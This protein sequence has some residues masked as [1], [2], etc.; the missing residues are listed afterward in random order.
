MAHIERNILQEKLNQAK[1]QI[2]IGDKYRHTKTGGEYL[3]KDLGIREDTE[4][5]DVIYEE[6]SHPEHI[7]WIRSLEG[8]DGWL[9]PTEINGELV[10][11]FTKIK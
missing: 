1:K 9:T 10:P 6:L 5:I 2:T 7:I 8:E 3:V 11:R 4:S